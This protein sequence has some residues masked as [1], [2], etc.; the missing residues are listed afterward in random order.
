LSGKGYIKNGKLMDT[1]LFVL[2]GAYWKTIEAMCRVRDHQRGDGGQHHLDHKT[3]SS[4]LR[5]IKRS[6]SHRC[7]HRKFIHQGKHGFFRFLASHTIPWQPEPEGINTAYGKMAE[8]I[9]P[10]CCPYKG[11][12]EFARHGR[13]TIMMYD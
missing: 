2:L 11:M 12:H 7:P 5:L 4:D 9:H 8:T 13:Q 3:G 1:R 10:F 6:L